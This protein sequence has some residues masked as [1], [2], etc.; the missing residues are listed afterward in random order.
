MRLIEVKAKSEQNERLE[1]PSHG[2]LKG[3]GKGT[4][5]PA[6]QFTF[7]RIRDGDIEEVKDT[8]KPR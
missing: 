3:G 4:M 1:H 2:P 8:P 7:R 5:W 6:D